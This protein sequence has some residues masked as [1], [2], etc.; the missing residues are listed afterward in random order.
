MSGSNLKRNVAGLIDAVRT[1]PTLALSTN[2]HGLC[3]G[4]QH[5]FYAFYLALTTAITNVLDNHG[6]ARG[7]GSMPYRVT[8]RGAHPLLPAIMSSLDWTLQNCEA[9]SRTNLEDLDQY[10]QLHACNPQRA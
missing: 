1:Q 5:R 10:T 7:S 6:H 8:D 3:E 9:L 4:Q 2:V